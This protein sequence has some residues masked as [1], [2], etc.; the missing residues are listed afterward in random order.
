MCSNFNCF[1][2]ACKPCACPLYLPSN[3]FSPNCA[4]ASA[5]GD[6][7]VCTQCPDGYTGDHCEHCDFGYWGSPTTP[8]GSCQPCDCGGAP[9]DRDTGLCGTCPPRTEGARCDQCQEGYWFGPDGWSGAGCVP[10]DCGVGALSVA[11]D[12]KTGQCACKQGFTGRRCDTCSAGH[13]DLIAGCPACRCGTAALSNSCAADTGVCAC[14]PGA[15][16]PYCDSCQDEHYGLESSGCKGCNCSPLGSESSVCDIRS[17]QCRCRPHVTG[18]AC[19]TCEVSW[20]LFA[21]PK[22][23]EQ[24][25]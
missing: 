9:C 3:N 5:E 8:G 20:P 2:G 7:F 16:L 19:D 22:G 1:Q 15:A 13:G 6:E 11:C 21:E 14:A 4:L 25:V 17:G 18:R 10:C 24:C 12:A 23:L